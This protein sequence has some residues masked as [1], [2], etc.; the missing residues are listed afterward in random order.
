MTFDRF[1][2]EACPGLDLEWRKYRRRSVGHR[3]AARLAESGL[4][5]YRDYLENRR[6][7]LLIIDRI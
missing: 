4:G 3:V 5:A 6:G 1:L 2:R 7:E